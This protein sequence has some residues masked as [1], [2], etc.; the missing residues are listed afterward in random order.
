MDQIVCWTLMGLRESGGFSVWYQL[1]SFPTAEEAN[2]AVA[3]PKIA[4]QG[5]VETQVMP[6]YRDQN[7]GATNTAATTI[8]RP[9]TA[10]E[11]PDQVDKAPTTAV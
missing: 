6:Y 5:F 2:Q 4:E 3:D 7:A 8:Q 10:S 9:S 1:D 11:V